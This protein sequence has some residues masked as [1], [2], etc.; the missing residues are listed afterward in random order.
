[1][2]RRVNKEFDAFVNV[3]TCHAPDKN[4]MEFAEIEIKT[5]KGVQLDTVPEKE[6]SSANSH[7]EKDSSEDGQTTMPEK[8]IAPVAAIE[9][10]LIEIEPDDLL[11]LS[12]EKPPQA[13][14]KDFSDILDM[15]IAQDPITNPLG[16]PSP[17]PVLLEHATTAGTTELPSAPDAGAGTTTDLLL[18]DTPPSSSPQPKDLHGQNLIEVF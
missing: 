1:M 12:D 6:V 17:S 3:V 9:E 8:E 11:D 18:L 4:E 5:A 10:N 16:A 13:P 7:E 14:A 2:G 15:P